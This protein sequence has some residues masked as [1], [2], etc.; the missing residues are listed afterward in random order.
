VL[1]QGLLCFYS[2][3]F[4]A[5]FEGSFKEA[6][7]RKIELSDVL[8]NTFEAFQVWLYSQSLRNFEDSQDSTK[9]LEF[10]SFQTLA[11]LWVFGD[12]YQIPLLQNSAIDALMS[13]LREGKSF[14]MTVVAIAYQHTMRASPLRK[15][16]IDTCVFRMSHPAGENSIFKDVNLCNWST[17]AFVDFAR[18]MSDAWERKLPKLV[19]P[20]RTK[21]YYHVHGT[22]EQ[23]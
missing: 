7:E 22:G 12:M 11:R 2:D 10:P 9:L 14:D 18:C 5:A 6:S 4:R 8:T 23:C 17:E 21:G 20:E 19:M 13:K 1:H 3:F 15:L 16:A